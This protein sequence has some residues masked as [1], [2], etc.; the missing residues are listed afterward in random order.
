MQNGLKAFAAPPKGNAATRGETPIL[1]V[2]V[3]K[4]RPKPCK[5]KKIK[6]FQ[7]IP[8]SSPQ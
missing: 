5:I 3:R 1:R 6:K 2:A 7:K 4:N 8:R